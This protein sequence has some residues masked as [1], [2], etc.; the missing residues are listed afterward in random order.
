MSG[1][2]R[3]TRAGAARLANRRIV[4]GKSAAEERSAVEVVRRVTFC[5]GHR[6]RG[7]ESKCRNI[8]GHNYTA[9][10]HAAPRI[11]LD[12]IGRVIDFAVLKELLGGWIEE[13]WDHGLLLWEKDEEAIAA[14][15]QLASQKLF[16][17]PSNP[18]AENLAY[19]LLHTVAPKVLAGADVIVTRVVLWETENCYAEVALRVW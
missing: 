17:L 6:I 12:A 1:I 18:T 7:H 5:A 14:V 19:E 3:Q 16:L 9:L 10:F 15:G 11:G 4:G 2:K 13:Q 8:H